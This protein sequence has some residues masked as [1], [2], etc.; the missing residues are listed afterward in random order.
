M[1]DFY[2]YRNEV[3][4]RKRKRKLM[5]ILILVLAA[6]CA[7]VGWFWMQHDAQ[8]AAVTSAEPASAETSAAPTEEPPTETPAPAQGKPLHA[9]YRPWIP[10][11]GILPQRS[12][13]PLTPN[14]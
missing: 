5:L 6:A 8:P 11:C 4:G 2:T 1:S 13:R 10:P 7:G 12:S 3:A 9:L 14:T